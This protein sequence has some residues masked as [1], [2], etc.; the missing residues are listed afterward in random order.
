MKHGMAV[1][2]P[3]TPQS[4]PQCSLLLCVFSN[5][6]FPP[7][8]LFNTDEEEEMNSFALNNFLPIYNSLSSLCKLQLEGTKSTGVWPRSQT[9]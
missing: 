4:F 7:R 1:M 5:I 3:G 8:L 2:P 9:Q 6:S